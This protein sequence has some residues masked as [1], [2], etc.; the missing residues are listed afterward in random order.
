VE[1]F[2]KTVTVSDETENKPLLPLCESLQQ[3][4]QLRTAYSTRDLVLMFICIL[5]TLGVKARLMMSLQPLPLKPSSQ[6]LCS[7]N[8]IREKKKSDPKED[9]AV[10]KV[11]KTDTRD[12][13][14]ATTSKKSLEDGKKCLKGKKS[15]S[16][17]KIQVEKPVD[18]KRKK[19]NKISSNSNLKS[20]TQDNKP[21]KRS[22]ND[23]DVSNGKSD[24]LKRTLRTR[25]ETMNMYKDSS[26][27]DDTSN[28]ETRVPCRKKQS[29]KTRVSSDGR[30]H[31]GPTDNVR[32]INQ[33]KSLSK[34]KESRSNLGIKT[35]SVKTKRG[36]SSQTASSIKK[37]S[38]SDSDS[39]FV[40]ESLSRWKSCDFKRTESA[41]SNSE[42]DFEPKKAT[43]KKKSTNGK[44]LDRRVI[45]SD[46]GT[47]IDG[48]GTQKKKKKKNCDVWTEVFVEEE[49]KWIS[50]DVQSGKLHCVAE[51]HV[52]HL[53]CI[54]DS[55]FLQHCEDVIVG[56]LGSNA[57]WTCQ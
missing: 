54:Y 30:S 17:S 4:F 7:I 18:D 14:Q 23:A 40:P 51:L 26:D 32:F 56:L 34:V 35:V 42:S 6:E 21:V 44:M 10:V 19:S 9:T 49:E 48:K 50:V 13:K 52:S 24:K 12:V 55:S 33:Q 25:K 22:R 5:R 27:E 41:D 46:S 8:K 3:S 2:K 53:I 15:E 31:K 45:A 43:Q 11:E 47:S 39:E 20:K 1:W 37:D 16:T 57:V 29:P 28:Q 36:N 38:N